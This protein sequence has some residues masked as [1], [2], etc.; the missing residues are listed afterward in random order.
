M[1]ALLWLGALG[2]GLWWLKSRAVA[3]PALTSAQALNVVLLGGTPAAKAAAVAAYQASKGL[4]PDGVYTVA[5]QDAMVD[6]GVATPA[7]LPAS[8]TED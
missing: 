8:V 6:D 2:L 7:P 4:P 3:S 5:I 1:P